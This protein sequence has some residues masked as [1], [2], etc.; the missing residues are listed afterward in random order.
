MKFWRRRED[1]VVEEEMEAMIRKLEFSWVKYY[2][3]IS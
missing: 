3:E 1:K 2:P